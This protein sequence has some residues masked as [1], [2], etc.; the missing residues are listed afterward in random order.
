MCVLGP[1]S[2]C[3]CFWLRWSGTA[4]IPFCLWRWR[5]FLFNRECA[6]SPAQLWPH[7]R[8][9]LLRGVFRR[10]HVLWSQESLSGVCRGTNFAGPD[11]LLLCWR[12]SVSF[13]QE[14]GGT[15]ARIHNQKVQ[16][17]LA[18]YLSQLET[19]NQ[20]SHSDFLTQNFWIGRFQSWVNLAHTV[21]QRYTVRVK[22][23]LR[24]AGLT[25]KPLKESFRW[26][27]GEILQFSSFAFG[28]P[29]N[30]G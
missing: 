4:Y 11:R 2:W 29:D 6:V 9:R 10:W 28:Q 8:W 20:L 18:F 19:N 5:I 1:T 12:V 23:H 13:L 25:F 14:R 27:S 3:F 21:L 16:D 15:L 7:G 17:I 24:S 30:Q 22:W 26:D